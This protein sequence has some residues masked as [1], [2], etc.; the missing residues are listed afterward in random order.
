M[1]RL[2]QTGWSKKEKRGITITSAAVTCFWTPTSQ[3][4]K[5]KNITFNIIDTPGAGF[6]HLS[7]EWIGC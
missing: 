4:I 3:L 1:E 6:S 5:Q 2:R 7:E